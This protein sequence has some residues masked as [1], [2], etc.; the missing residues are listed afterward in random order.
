MLGSRSGF[1]ALVKRKNPTAIHREALASKTLPAAL[2]AHQETIIKKVNFIKGSVLNMRLFLELCE[3]MDAEH[4]ALLFHTQVRGLSKGNMPTWFYEEVKTFLANHNKDELL[5]K[6]NMPEFQGD[7]YEAV[8]ELNRK[9]QCH[10]AGGG[11]D[12]PDVGSVDLSVPAG[13][14]S[15][16]I[17]GGVYHLP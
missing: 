6:T 15:G 17:G 14:D 16:M 3:N 2:H 4:Q 11:P 7:I 10:A 13:A 9:L 8:N 1:L 12:D 5:S